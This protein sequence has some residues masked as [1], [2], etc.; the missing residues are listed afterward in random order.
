MMHIIELRILNSSPNTKCSNTLLLEPAVMSCGVRLV[1]NLFIY[2]V[3]P[4][5][6]TKQTDTYYAEPY[7]QF[8]CAR[9]LRYQT[10]FYKGSLSSY[11]DQFG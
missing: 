6:K 11:C 9:K 8:K 1:S 7:R 3:Y 10:D 2:I 5:K 4:E